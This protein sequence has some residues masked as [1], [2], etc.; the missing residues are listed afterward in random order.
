[1]SVA[2]WAAGV[3]Q[4]W[5]KKKICPLLEDTHADFSQMWQENDAPHWRT[6]HA[7]DIGQMWQKM[8]PLVGGLGS[9]WISTKCSP[10]APCWSTLSHCGLQPNVVQNVPLVGGFC[11]TADF[12][13]MW[14][15]MCPLLEDFVMLRTSTKCGLNMCPLTEH[16]VLLWSLATYGSITYSLL[17]GQHKTNS[18][19]PSIDAELNRH[20]QLHCQM[21]NT[22]DGIHTNKPWQK[23]TH[24]VS[25]RD[26]WQMT[27]IAH[28]HHQ[29]SIVLR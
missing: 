28:N 2:Y 13:Q 20:L 22:L 26:K 25:I 29:C 19:S 6:C 27:R 3:A 4:I 8:M 1:M 24:L 16:F 15:E 12:N 23:M 18:P 17:K 21:I 5:H 11:L 10:N 7:A 9:L 14:S